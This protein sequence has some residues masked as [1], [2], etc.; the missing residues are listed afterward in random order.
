MEAAC[1]GLRLY[2]LDLRDNHMRGRSHNH[3]LPPSAHLRY[4]FPDFDIQDSS[5]RIP[6]S[7]IERVPRHPPFRHLAN[8][9]AEAPYWS[10]DKR[11]VFV[12]TF[13]LRPYWLFY[14]DPDFR[15]VVSL[16]FYVE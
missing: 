11:G 1:S 9:V 4:P 7:G 3:S 15:R 6:R 8:I 10:M 14:V 13:T 12:T 16:A 2:A 5:A